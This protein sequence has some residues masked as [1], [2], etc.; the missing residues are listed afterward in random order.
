MSFSLNEYLFGPLD[1][2]F[3]VYFYILSV[4]QFTVGIF[5]LG[6]L[7]F[8]LALGTKKMTTSSVVTILMGSV[9]YFI[10][11]MQSRLFSGMCKR[12]ESMCNSTMPSNKI[13]EA[14]S[15]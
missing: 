1:V 12:K 8:L 15:N 7:L 11:Y 9:A 4:I 14:Y 13:K 6:S 2:E 10:L 3:C 5:T